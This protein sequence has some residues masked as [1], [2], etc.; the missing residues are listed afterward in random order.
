VGDPKTQN[1][2]LEQTGLAKP[3]KTPELTDIGAG[4][5]RQDVA[6]LVFEQFWNQTE[7]FVRSKP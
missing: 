6:G 7:L 5:A 2:R 4:L 1:Q 3:T